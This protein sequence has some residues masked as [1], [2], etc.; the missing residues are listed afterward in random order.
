MK[1]TILCIALLLGLVL[2]GCILFKQPPTNEETNQEEPKKDEITLLLENLKQKTEIAFS[3]IQ[4]LVFQWAV[5]ASS[6]GGE[7]NPEAQEVTI[8]GKGFEAQKITTE[9]YERVET[10]LTNND[11]EKDLH[12]IA[13]GTVSGLAGYKK[14]QTVCVVAGGATG[15][16]EA[17][18]EWIPPEPDIKDVEI[19]CGLLE[20]TE[21]E[22]TDWQN[23][24]NE[25]YGYS[26]SYP[27]NCLLG[28][29]PGECKQK[30][31]EERGE[32][33]LCFL[34]EENPDAVLLQ[35]LT[36]E[37]EKLTGADFSVVHYD[38]EPYNPPVD[39]DL[40]EWLKEK[41]THQEI[42]DEPN[43]EIDGIT[44]VVVY[45]PASPGAYSQE[46]IYF[47]KDDK[48][49]NVSLLDVDN[50][51]NRALYNRLLSAFQFSKTIETKVDEIFTITLAANPTTGYE[52]QIDSDADFIE[53]VD[54]TY[55][56]ATDETLVGAGGEETL[57]FKALK[58]GETR[59]TF[60]Y[61]R[62]WESKP[63]IKVRDY[64]ITIE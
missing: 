5:P 17:E 43:T 55:K 16:K 12:N 26:F 30:P 23:Y 54:K 57:N 48:L 20:E 15:Y 9:Q 33:C 21:K 3:D 29:L 42:P 1:K 61:S 18:G 28:P 4:G 32:E 35:T 56:A 37:G 7:L 64:K 22:T 39:T 45:T 46:N 25:K 62:E 58:A 10:Y 40:I 44:A 31:P 6:A 53:L 38:T 63:P 50:E 27:A 47:I 13:D 41:F 60:S 11:F 24:E 49:F 59:I 34:N 2:T 52:W 19:K 8:Q 51:N 14:N 36:G